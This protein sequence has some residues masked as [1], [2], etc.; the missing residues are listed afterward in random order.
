MAEDT[1]RGKWHDQVKEKHSEQWNSLQNT[2]S[3]WVNIINYIL[4]NTI[5]CSYDTSLGLQ[6][7][8]SV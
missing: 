3:L 7:V 2:Q 4:C 6:A 8:T 5:T 1:S